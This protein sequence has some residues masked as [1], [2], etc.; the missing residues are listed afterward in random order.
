ML[1]VHLKFLSG[2]WRVPLWMV[3]SW[4]GG[5]D[6]QE[7]HVNKETKTILQRPK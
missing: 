5:E 3:D 1:F 7:E 2:K 4:L 6:P